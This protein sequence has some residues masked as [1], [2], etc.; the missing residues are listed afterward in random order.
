MEYNSIADIYAANRSIRKRFQRTVDGITSDEANAELE[1]EKWTVAALVEHVS[2]VEFNM[3]RIC[4]KLLAAAKETGKSGDGSFS[5]SP[6]FA[7]KSATIVDQKVEAPEFV[8][9]KGGVAIS[10]SVEKLDGST[11]ELEAMRSDFESLD[12][13]DHKFPHPFFGGLTAAEWLL[14][15]GR[16]EARHLAQIERLLATI[17]Q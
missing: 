6:E 12:V 5:I 7:A 1:G 9:P 13:T 14:I 15:A 2:I 17:R 8:H 10:E 16:H 11:V 4:G 3:S